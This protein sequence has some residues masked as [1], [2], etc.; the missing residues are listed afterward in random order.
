MSVKDVAME[1]FSSEGNLECLNLIYLKQGWVKSQ[2]QVHNMR[3]I[4]RID[5]VNVFTIQRVSKPR[6]QRFKV[7]NS[8]FFRELN[9]VSMGKW[10][11]VIL[12]R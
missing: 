3:G 12:A 9:L 4:D 5:H 11:K 7:K 10:E 6:G 1:H 2:Y 8:K